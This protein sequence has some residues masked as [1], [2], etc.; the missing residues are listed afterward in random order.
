MPAVSKSSSCPWL[1]RQRR[2][3]PEAAPRRAPSNSSPSLKT[4][5]SATCAAPGSAA[6]GS[7]MVCKASIGISI[8]SA[9]TARQLARPFSMRRSATLN[10][11]CPLKSRRQSGSERGGGR[12]SS[13]KKR[14]AAM[15]FSVPEKVTVDWPT[16]SSLPVTGA[17]PP[18]LERSSAG[19]GSPSFGMTPSHGARRNCWK[20][21]LPLPIG[22]PRSKQ[23]D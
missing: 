1:V 19:G 4:W 14:P 2:R 6:G 21:N 12:L 3:S 5:R 16:A 23:M 10:S 13:C 7:E 17:S 18:K 9:R 22:K 8:E 15:G 11:P 20:R